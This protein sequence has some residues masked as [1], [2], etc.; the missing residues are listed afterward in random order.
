M[1]ELTVRELRDALKAKSVDLAAKARAEKARERAMID[2]A[3]AS[4]SSMP[5]NYWQ[6]RHAAE[7]RLFNCLF[8][9]E[10]LDEAVAG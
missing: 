4:K 2:D 9:L 6:P 7:A 1:A 3:V 8:L 10:A 5:N